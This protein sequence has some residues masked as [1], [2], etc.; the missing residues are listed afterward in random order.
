L[1]LAC[2]ILSDPSPFSPNIT[3]LFYRREV[4]TGTCVFAGTKINRVRLPSA[5]LKRDSVNAHSCVEQT[6]WTHRMDCDLADAELSGA[7]RSNL[8]LQ[9]DS[10][11]AGTVSG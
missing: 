4:S 6:W 10:R 8:A 3:E 7:G 5:Y 9:H 11:P 1:A 2:A